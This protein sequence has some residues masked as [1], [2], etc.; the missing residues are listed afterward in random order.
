MVEVPVSAARVSVGVV[1]TVLMTTLF[2]TA[3][4]EPADTFPVKVIAP[5]LL[6]GA[7]LLLT[8]KPVVPLAKVVAL[9]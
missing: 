8:A 2:K 7:V 3:D 4:T 9:P 5:A 6:P 1:A